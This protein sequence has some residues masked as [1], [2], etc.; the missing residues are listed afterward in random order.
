MRAIWDDG[1][2][3]KTAGKNRKSAGAT[4]QSIERGS[5]AP[6]GSGFR[7][8]DVVAPLSESDE[9]VVGIVGPVGG[10][11]DKLV[12]TIEK[13]MDDYGYK[14]ENCRLS[15]FFE[16][17]EVKRIAGKV[18]TKS[19]FDRINTSMDVGDNLRHR[20]KRD[21]ILALYAAAQISLRRKKDPTK[22]PLPMGRTVHI[23]RSL[24]RP[25]EVASLRLTYGSNF[26]LVGAYVPRDERVI[27]LKAKMTEEDAVAL[28]RRDE[29]GGRHGQATSRTF[30]L[31]DLFVDGTLGE[32]ALVE[33][34]HRFFDLYFGCPFV[35]P[36]KEEH[37]MFL[38]FAASLRSGD[39]SRQVG[40]VVTT[41]EGTVLSE[42]ANDAPQYG[43]GQYWP[44]ENDQRDIVL[45]RDSNED[46]KRQMA[47]KV[48]RA[49]KV[50]FDRRRNTPEQI[51]ELLADSGMLDITEFGRAVHAEMSAILSCARIGVSTKETI[52]YSTTFPCHNCAKHIVA[53][54]IT[55]VRFIEPYPKSK[56]FI[57]HRD[58]IAVTDVHQRVT[59]LPFVGIGPRRYVE[60]FALKDAFGIPVRRKDES[61]KLIAWDRRNSVPKIAHRLV[62]YL[63]LEEWA[64]AQI[65]RAVQEA[66]RRKRASSR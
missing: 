14:P 24:K 36:R 56:A 39:L 12:R 27:N 20:T 46:A 28:V 59:F 51:Q 30:E 9:L 63:E 21:E 37:A 6:S 32:A 7:R 48:L 65:K 52:L 43:G 22:T 66:T 26:L 44:G 50:K 5:R 11:F 2:L 35:T 42:G 23:L 19:E 31:A 41:K 33:E 4:K 16:L 18:S 47:E 58:A 57:L 29:G 1:A 10:D 15:Q 25:E 40:A 64:L 61:G 55:H 49:C 3:L 54:G 17:D 38:A 62:N 34:L 45:G 53:A 60:L 8:P 13:C